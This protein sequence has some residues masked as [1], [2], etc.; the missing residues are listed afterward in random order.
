MGPSLF[1][2]YNA[3]AVWQPSQNGDWWVM[4]AHDTVSGK[5]TGWA[6]M[7]AA[8]GG[9]NFTNFTTS[10]NTGLVTANIN[11]LD[12]WSPLVIVAA[13][14]ES[15]G[16]LDNFTKQILAAPLTVSANKEVVFIWHGH[17]YEFTPGPSTWKGN[18][19]QPRIDGK[20]VEIDPPFLY[21]SP[22][23]NAALDSEVVT[24]SYGTYK[25]V[26]NFTDDT[27]TR[28]R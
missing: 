11:P 26:Y 13:D 5:P 18:W 28:L 1:N 6:A 21:S 3:S 27:I 25:L 14:A 4:A 10:S 15:Y 2:V 23:L 8:W 22:H 17:R 9:T 20:P 24:A 7:R 19:T 16:T 12:T